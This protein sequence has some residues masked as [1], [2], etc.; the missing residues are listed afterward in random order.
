MRPAARGGCTGTSMYLALVRNKAELLGKAL[1]LDPYDALLDEFSPGMTAAEIDG[2]FTT[3]DQRSD[4]GSYF[5]NSCVISLNALNSSA[6]PHGSS[7]NI[8][9][10]SPT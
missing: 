2:I 1:K 4:A 3:V 5:A 8:V 7:R 6:F 10:C 9:A